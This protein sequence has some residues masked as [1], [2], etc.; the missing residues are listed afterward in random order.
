MP[1]YQY[2]TNQEL[3]EIAAEKQMRLLQDRRVFQFMPI[4]TVN[5][6]YLAWEQRDGYR[7]L[8]AV[9]GLNGKPTRIR[10]EGAK[11]FL[12]EPGV[13]GEF[14]IVDEAEMTRR[15]EGVGVDSP[16]VIDDLVGTI[17]DILLG[18]ELDRQEYIAWVLLANGTFAV[19]TKDGQ[20]LHTDSYTMQQ[21]TAVTPW[22]TLATAAPLQNFRDVKLLARGKG[23]SFGRQA[24]AFMNEITLNRLMGNTNQNDLGGKKTTKDEVLAIDGVRKLMLDGDLPGIEV[25]D[26]GYTDDNGTFVPFLSDGK[27]VIIGARRGG[28]TIADYALTRNAN[29]PGNAPGSYDKVRDLKDDVP[30]EIQVHRGHNGG[31]RIYYPG[32]VVVMNV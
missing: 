17:Q 30:P 1:D 4:V 23:V 8:Q 31:P 27:V 20:V 7:G 6:H 13:Y 2:P 19:M 14:D 9:R 5:A 22:A 12:M 16:V 24:T 28:E 11:R 3:K 15:A 26:N 25:E 29:N 18:R 32:S 21:Y 10:R